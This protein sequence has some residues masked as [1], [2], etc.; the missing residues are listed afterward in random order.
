MRA[1]VQ[2]VKYASVAI[3]GE[4]TAQIGEGLL[5]LAGF[6]RA[7]TEEDFIYT[8]EKCLNLRI[9]NDDGG[10]MN[11]SLKDING[12]ILAVSQFTLYGDARKG[13]RPSYFDAAPPDEAKKLYNRFIEVLK[14]RYS[15]VKTGV[16]Q[17]DMD[18][19]SVNSGPVTIL[20]DS[21]KDF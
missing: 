3:C 4:I 5:I 15:S 11:L 14:E 13:R 8:A 10:K 18:V 2:R 20:I 19:E 6:G 16:F 21:K 9:F 1:V 17:A 7:D 12:E